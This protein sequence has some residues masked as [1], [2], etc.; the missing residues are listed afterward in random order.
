M[1]DDPNRRGRGFDLTTSPR[2]LRRRWCRLQRALSTLEIPPSYTTLTAGSSLS[3]AG[4]DLNFMSLCCYTANHGRQAHIVGWKSG[5]AS[6]TSARTSDCRSNVRARSPPALA[7]SLS[8]LLP[9]RIRSRLTFSLAEG[10][11]E[12]LFIEGDERDEEDGDYHPSQGPLILCPHHEY[13]FD[14]LGGH[15]STGMKACTYRLEV[16]EGGKL[17]MEALGDVGDD[18]RV[19]G[20]RAVSER[21]L[22]L[23]RRLRALPCNRLC[24]G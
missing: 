13:D 8:P 19:I 20:L 15:S 17:W 6:P 18:Y 4:R 1:W 14:L 11:I 3:A 5:T 7:S 10:D 22:S 16:R 21:A 9:P 24:V 12:D 23:S 2:T